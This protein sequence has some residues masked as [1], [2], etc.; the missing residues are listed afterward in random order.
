MFHVQ[1]IELTLHRADIMI[2]HEPNYAI[3]CDDETHQVKSYFPKFTD[4]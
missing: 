1:N 2:T 3:M 4:A